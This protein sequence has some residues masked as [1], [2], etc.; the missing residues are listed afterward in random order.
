MSINDLT[1]IILPDARVFNYGKY[2]KL[3]K[4]EYIKQKLNSNG[5]KII[6]LPK[7]HQKDDFF[8]FFY[9]NSTHYKN[10]TGEIIKNTILYCLN[11]NQDLDC[12]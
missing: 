1:I 10:E 2:R 9:S 4:I 12:K 7:F 8:D 11:K 3:Y 5:I 6:D